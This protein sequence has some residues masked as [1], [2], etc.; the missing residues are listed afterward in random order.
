MLEILL[1]LFSLDISLKID[2]EPHSF[3]MNSNGQYPSITMNNQ[4]WILQ[5]YHKETV[6]G[7]KLR[8]RI[9]HLHE[10]RILWSNTHSTYNKGFYPNI[11]INNKGL[12]VAVFASQVG[13]TVWY[14]L[15]QLKFTKYYDP[16]TIP[17]SEVV[18]NAFVYWRDTKI[19]LGQGMNPVVT[20]S[21]DNTV[22]VAFDSGFLFFETSYRIGDV[23]GEAIEWRG[24]SK[25]LV[26]SQHTKHASIA[27]NKDGLVAIGYSNGYTRTIHYTSGKISTDNDSKILMSETMYT[28]P[29]A[30]FHPIVSLNN[31]GHVVAVFHN[32]QGRLNLKI[33]HGTV[34]MNTSTQLPC[35]E[36]SH[37]APHVFAINGYHPSVAVNDQ[38]DMVTSHKSLLTLSVKK[39]IRNYVGHLSD[40]DMSSPLLS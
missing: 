9:G 22:V 11:A 29:G 23:R 21:D 33:N 15:G 5:V 3:Y 8:C 2:F 16:V 26:N 6:V 35:I 36:W 37:I 31:H 1:N 17:S 14:R 32:L 40:I 4:G 10:K 30:N 27:I 7:L 28:P 13:R 24:N 19:L 34:K 18:N 39:S 12:V 25:C 38:L 20:L